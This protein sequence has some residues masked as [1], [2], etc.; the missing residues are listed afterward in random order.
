MKKTILDLARIIKRKNYSFEQLWEYIHNLK[1]Y[2]NITLRDMDKA[3]YIAKN[4]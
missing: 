2:N 3:F 4:S 1:K